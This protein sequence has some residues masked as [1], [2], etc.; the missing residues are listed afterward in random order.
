MLLGLGIAHA[1]ETDQAWLKPVQRVL[2]GL[3]VVLAAVAGYFLWA[4]MH[5]RAASDVSS[6]LEMRSPEDYLTGMVHLLDLTPESVADLRVP[7]ILSSLSILLAF[8]AAW[9]LRE[10]GIR[11]LP[12]IALALGMVGFILAAHIAHDVL[13]PDAFL[14]FARAGDQQSLCGPTIRSRCMEIFASLPA[15]HFIPTGTCCCTTRPEAIW[16]SALIIRTPRN[17]FSTI[18]IFPRSGKAAG[19]CFWLCRMEH[20][21][22]VRKRL[23]GNSMWVFAETGGKTVY[24]NQSPEV[25]QLPLASLEGKLKLTASHR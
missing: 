15:L 4:T 9:I 8:V 6:H 5:I 3:S 2:A 24:V 23:P 20:K 1:E 7:I 25:G 17:G 13:N 11:W 22:E 14:P 12:T 10:R 21:E 19:A 16:N 18:W